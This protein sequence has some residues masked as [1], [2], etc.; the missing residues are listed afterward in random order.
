MFEIEFDEKRLLLIATL[1]GYWSIE[2]FDRYKAELLSTMR[3]IRKRH[4]FFSM[5]S[6]SAALPV[7]PP[8]IS[9]GFTAMIG[10]LDNHCPGRIAIMVGSVLNKIQAS[11]I[12][13]HPRIGIFFD[14][15]EALHWLIDH[16]ASATPLRRRA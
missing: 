16:H 14:E 3:N 7:Q 4:P 13:R 9:A 1:E 2:I 10:D 11:R 8:E 6:R 5:L 12:L 15:D